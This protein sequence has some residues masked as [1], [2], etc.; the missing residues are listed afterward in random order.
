MKKILAILAGLAGLA[1]GNA[2]AATV[3]TDIQGGNLLLG[4]KVPA[5]VPLSG[6]C[7]QAWI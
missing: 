6:P 1:I 2:R 3:N 7:I 5:T 4:F